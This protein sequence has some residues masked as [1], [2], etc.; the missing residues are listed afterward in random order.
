M[1]SDV[2]GRAQDQGGAMTTTSAPAPVAP[3]TQG[4]LP[5][6]RIVVGLAV[7]YL[8][9]F[10][11]LMASGSDRAPDADPAKIMADYN[12]SDLGIRLI[13]FG[14]VIAAAVLVFLGGSLRSLL[15]ARTRRWTADVAS[16]GFAVVGVTIVGF[17]MSTLALHHAIDI[18]DK[19]VV[20]AIN[21]LDTTNYP[22][23]MLGMACAMIGVGVA[24]LGEKALP[25]WLCWV[26]V[27][28]GVMSPLGPLGFAPF[29][30]F[31]VWAVLVACLVRLP[32]A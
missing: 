32:E 1:R 7:V 11:V 15:V 29:L 18:G 25:S 19:T 17:E 6:R 9:F 28:L 8:I 10:F 27:V 21:V 30:L 12:I 20:Q 4:P 16:L 24:A 3:T 13:T 2:S 22:L 14:T 5:G 31:P 23:A 26:S